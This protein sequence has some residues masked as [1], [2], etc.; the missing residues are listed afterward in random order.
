MAKPQNPL[1]LIKKMILESSRRVYNISQVRDKELH[2]AAVYDE[3]FNG[4]ILSPTIV[5]AMM[6]QFIGKIVTDRFGQTEEFVSTNTLDLF[7][8]LDYK[9]TL[10]LRKE[11]ITLGDLGLDE[12][13]IITEQKESNI[14]TATTA[15]GEWNK[16]K[17]LVEPLLLSNPDWKWRDAA[18]HLKQIGVV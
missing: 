15:L 3:V 14:E 18:D 5:K 17:E 6:Y 11:V 1:T 12:I 16:A 2:V 7:Y 13:Q 10:V 8:D 4:N 9:F